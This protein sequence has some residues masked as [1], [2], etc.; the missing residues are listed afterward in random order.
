[1]LTLGVLLAVVAF[2]GVLLFGSTPGNTAPGDN[3][4]ANVTV[5]TAAQGLL[6]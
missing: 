3:P 4:G 6:R 5:V 2:G 1:M